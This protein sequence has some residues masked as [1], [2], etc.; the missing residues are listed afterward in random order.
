MT[1]P[2]TNLADLTTKQLEG[3]IGSAERRLHAL[4]AEMGRRE[5]IAAYGT[6]TPDLR[7]YSVEACANFS[8][9]IQARDEADARRVLDETTW[10]EWYGT[11]PNGAI[12]VD[13]FDFGEDMAPADTIPDDQHTNR[14]IHPAGAEPVGHA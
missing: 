10:L 12:T 13:D 6:E 7:E 4:R 8:L 1:K 11:T 2:K 5:K 9:S 14:L 3:Q